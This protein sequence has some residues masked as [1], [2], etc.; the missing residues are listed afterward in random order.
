MKI[1]VYRRENN[2]FADC[3][4]CEGHPPLGKGNTQEEAIGSLIMILYQEKVM[5][6]HQITPGIDVQVFHP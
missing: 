6:A 5:W 4:D 1:K 2:W 3:L